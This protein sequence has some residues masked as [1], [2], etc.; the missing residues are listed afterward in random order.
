[1]LSHAETAHLVRLAQRGQPEAFADLVRGFLR[2]TYAV[3]LSIVGRPADAED[4]A[5]D[6]FVN[7]FAHLDTCREPERFA[8]WL[9]QIT[10]NLARNLLDRRRLRDVAGADAKVIEL[11]AAPAPTI[12]LREPLLAALATL[13]ER[14][15]AVV[16][17][18]DL[19][20]WTHAEIAAVLEISE[21]LS[22]Q[23]LF[24]ARRVL[25]AHLDGE[26]PREGHH[27]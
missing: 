17:L 23:T 24:Q 13:D 3:A 2:A 12:G 5:Q 9:F 11:S 27:G 20:G 8:G 4:V 18:H 22:R 14:A 16:L 15:R 10:R 19:E 7:A 25:R 26:L 21:V 1:M 6:S